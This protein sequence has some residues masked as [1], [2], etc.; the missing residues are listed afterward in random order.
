MHTESAT[1]VRVPYSPIRP[2]FREMDHLLYIVSTNGAVAALSSSA[3]AAQLRRARAEKADAA[4]FNDAMQKLIDGGD[5]AAYSEYAA[6]AK[7]KRE[8]VSA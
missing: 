6:F 4:R 8:E 1:Q 7:A 5:L 3:P 2:D